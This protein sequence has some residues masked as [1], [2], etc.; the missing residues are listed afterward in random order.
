LNKNGQQVQHGDTRHMMFTLPEIISYLSRY[1]TLQKGDLIYTGTPA[2]VGP[3]KNGD[4][5]QGTLNGNHVL[6][7]AI[8]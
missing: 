4:E 1:F 3:V 6:N 7:C 2:G 5:L 8:K